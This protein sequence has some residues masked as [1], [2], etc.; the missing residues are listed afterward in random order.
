MPNIGVAQI[1]RLGELYAF[2]ALLVFLALMFFQVPLSR[3]VGLPTY[4]DELMLIA[5]FVLICFDAF[6]NP[7]ARKIL[8]LFFVGY[9]FL[10]VISVNAISARGLVNVLVQIFIH[11]KVIV[12]F[13]F[14]WIYLK[15]KHT[16]TLLLTIALITIVALLI[17]LGTGPLFN[18]IFDVDVLRRAGFVR[19]IGIQADTASLGTTLALLTIFFVITFSAK[20]RKS[21]LIW[22]LVFTCFVFLTSSRT[23]LIV[24]PIIVTWWLRE[25]VRSFVLVGVF[26]LIGSLF[27][28]SNK[29][30]QDIVEITQQNIEWTVD[31]PVESAYIRGIMLFFSF[32]LA[33]QNFPLGTGAAT[34]GTVNS[35]DS[36]VYA[37][38]GLRNS[39]FFVE[40]EGIYDSNFASLL[41]EFGYA[42]LIFYFALMFKTMTLFKGSQQAQESKW[43]QSGE[44]IYCTALTMFV[45]SIATPIFMN[46]YPAFILALLF[47]SSYKISSTSEVKEAK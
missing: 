7:Q 14:A 37:E 35:D 31:N 25:S 11:L 46:S 32:E 24:V 34:Y 45:F 3:A 43:E 20:N 26:V 44:F 10:L 41:G 36:Y 42:G 23:S 38:I 4:L 18:Q 39:R 16:R 47:V 22:L 6:K 29:Y 33:N 5:F 40:R 30:V 9:L 2:V 12:I 19:P 8:T 28:P 17:N 1:R 27:L 15:P 13:G 21:K